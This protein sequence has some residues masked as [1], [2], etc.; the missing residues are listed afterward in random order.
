MRPL[1]QMKKMTAV[2]RRRSF[3]IRG[4][5]DATPQQNC[6]FM[7]HEMTLLRSS[8]A[9]E[10]AWNASLCAGHGSDVSVSLGWFEAR[11][12][13]ASQTFQ[14]LDNIQGMSVKED[15]FRFPPRMK[16][17]C[18]RLRLVRVGTTAT[19]VIIQHCLPSAKARRRRLIELTQRYLSST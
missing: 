17:S 1:P 3:A 7:L 9:R 14:V 4:L 13:S 16:R 18:N 10:S 12:E 5:L 6:G 19:Q 11:E 2:L 8:R 15:L